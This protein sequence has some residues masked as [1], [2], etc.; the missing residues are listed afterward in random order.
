MKTLHS[1]PK[2]QQQQ[3][4]CKYFPQNEHQSGINIGTE[5]GYC[6][7][8]SQYMDA[9]PR[10]TLQV[11]EKELNVTKKT[12]ERVVT[13]HRQLCDAGHGYFVN[14]GSE[15]G[16]SRWSQIKIDQRKEENNNSE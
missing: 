16:W 10:R 2:Q 11:L 14:L 12:I 1:K 5:M 15:K 3:H 7:S 4:K 8:P 13:E 6:S 9:V